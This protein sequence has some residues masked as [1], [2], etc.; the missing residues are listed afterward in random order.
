MPGPSIVA[1]LGTGSTEHRENGTS[2]FA[3]AW[4]DS[5]PA[6][7]IRAS[8]KHGDSDAAW[9]GLVTRRPAQRQAAYVRFD[10]R[11]DE[12]PSALDDVDNM[13][14]VAQ[15]AR[16]TALNSRQV[17]LLA[18]CIRAELFVFELDATRPPRLKGGAYRCIGH[19]YCRLRAGT[20]K[21]ATFMRQLAQRSA[22]FQCQGRPLPSGSAFL[23]P[24]SGTAD[25]DDAN[26]CQ[27]V[28]FQV[29]SRHALCRIALQ[30]APSSVCDISGSPFTLDGLVK[31]QKL[32]A[33]FG[34]D[35]HR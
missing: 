27:T 6:R 29:S 9:K 13:D 10:I 18:R 24:A 20:V 11:L 32:D 12:A 35:D 1:S 17:A 25:D 5:Y 26:F 3:A 2:R 23:L 15:I 4:E 33:A 34:R 16:D 19:I 21:F 14:L 7:L 22:V 28:V 31:Q 30:E 8:L